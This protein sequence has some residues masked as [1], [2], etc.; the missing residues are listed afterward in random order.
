MYIMSKDKILA[1]KFFCISLANLLRRC[2]LPSVD[3]YLAKN[4]GH[5][6][7]TSRVDLECL[8]FQ[9]LNLTNDPRVSMVW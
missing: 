1:N 9:I 4:S 6:H 8:S 2:V 7:L 3:V 5:I